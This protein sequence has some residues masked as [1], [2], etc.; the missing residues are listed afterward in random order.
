MEFSEFLHAFEFNDCPHV[1]AAHWHSNGFR[2]VYLCVYVWISMWMVT[3]V[4]TNMFAENI[5]RW[6]VFDALFFFPYLPLLRKRQANRTKRAVAYQAFFNN[7]NNKFNV[8]ELISR[9]IKE[10]RRKW[11][12]KD[13]WINVFYTDVEHKHTYTQPHVRVREREL[14]NETIR[15]NTQLYKEYVAHF[16]HRVQGACILENFIKYFC[17]LAFNWFCLEDLDDFVVN[18]KKNYDMFLMC[19]IKCEWKN[20]TNTM[21]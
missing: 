12:H 14:L 11:S 17:F 7:N 3:N 18:L 20:K 19:F 5:N 2:I 4:G 10:S 16:I 8:I 15:A 21:G 13:H 6:I 1:S 9:H